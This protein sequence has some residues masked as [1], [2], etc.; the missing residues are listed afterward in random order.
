MRFAV[1]VA[2]ACLSYHR[3]VERNVNDGVK[4]SR[5]SGVAAIVGGGEAL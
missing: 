2:A 5:H 4:A 1:T 3:K